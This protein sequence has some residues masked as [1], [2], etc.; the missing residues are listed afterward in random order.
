[1]DHILWQTGEAHLL[2]TYERG[3]QRHVLVCNDGSEIDRGRCD[4]HDSRLEADRH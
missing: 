3:M 1:M 2:C 4:C